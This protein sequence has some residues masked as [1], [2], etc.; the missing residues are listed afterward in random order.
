VVLR[1]RGA[2]AWVDRGAPDAPLE[3]G[4][5]RFY[6]VRTFAHDGR[7]SSVVSSVTTATTAPLPKPPTGLRAFSRQPRSVPLAW[8]ASADPVVAGYTVERSP[9][10]DGPFEVVAELEGRHSTH[11][12]DTGLGDL[13]VLYYRVSSRNPGGQRGAPTRVL[14]AVT[15]PAPLPPISLHAIQRRLGAIALA[16]E[17][18]VETDLRGYLV[19]RWREGHLPELVAYVDAAQTRAEDPGV[20]AE[21]TYFY[22]VAALDRDGLESRRSHAV[23]VDSIGYEWTASASP[24]EI[25]LRWNPRTDE[26]FV[27]ARVTRSGGLW[28]EKIFLTQS[29]ELVDRDVTP[30]RQY[31]YRIGLERA[32]GETAPPSRPI[33]IEPPRVGF[34]E[35]QAPTSRIPQPEGIPR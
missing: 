17:P 11:V 18:N 25:R 13:R 21:R 19:R 32:N 31:R 16:W 3:D 23:R 27:R 34:V 6:R 33:E 7:V 8:N 26:G 12:L 35:I 15:K 20:S 2:L 22:S 14:R 29:A 28:R 24:E 1:D 5:T 10:P 4:A 9:R 30:G